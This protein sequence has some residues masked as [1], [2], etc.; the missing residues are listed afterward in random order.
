LSFCSGR[1]DVLAISSCW[2]LRMVPSCAWSLTRQSR[3][4][5]LILFLTTE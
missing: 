1:L 2:D 5:F 3:T 4:S